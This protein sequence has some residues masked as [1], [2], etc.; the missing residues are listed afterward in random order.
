MIK[1]K[2]NNEKYLNYQIPFTQLQG[3]KGNGDMQAEK[4]D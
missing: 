2:E 4:R 3:K 1:Y